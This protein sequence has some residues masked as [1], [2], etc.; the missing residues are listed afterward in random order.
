MKMNIALVLSALG[1]FLIHCVWECPAVKS[2]WSI[3]I[4]ILTEIFRELF[5][6]FVFCICVNAILN[7][8]LGTCII[9]QSYY[10]RQEKTICGLATILQ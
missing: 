2:F 9:L 10:H 3:V 8:T 1:L 6:A 4:N 5:A 7:Q